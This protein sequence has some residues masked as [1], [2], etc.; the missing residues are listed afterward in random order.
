M[1]YSGGALIYFD[2]KIYV[3]NVTIKGIHCHVVKI[4]MAKF[5]YSKNNLSASKNTFFVKLILYKGTKSNKG[6][7]NLAFFTTMITVE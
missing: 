7:T 1:T 3:F 2:V 5:Y 4:K 6:L